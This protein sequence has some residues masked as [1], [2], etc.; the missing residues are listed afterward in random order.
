MKSPKDCM[1]FLYTAL[2]TAMVVANNGAAQKYVLNVMDRQNSDY[3]L[4]LK[5][6]NDKGVIGQFKDFCESVSASFGANVGPSI[7][8]GTTGA[9]L[10]V[11]WVKEQTD[12]IANSV[13]DDIMANLRKVC[14]LKEL[15]DTE[16]TAALSTVSKENDPIARLASLFGSGGSGP[17][18]QDL[19]N[20]L[21]HPDKE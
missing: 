6:F 4:K 12:K 20:M 15:S 2:Q 16:L 9:F 14:D 21:G 3:G 17:S 19:Q 1:M 7:C 18:F 10:F 13:L 8:T 11:K 5:A